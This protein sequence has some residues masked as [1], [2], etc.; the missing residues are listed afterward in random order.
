MQQALHDWGDLIHT[1]VMHPVPITML[2]P[3]CPTTS[4]PVMPP[5]MGWGGLVAQLFDFRQ[6]ANVWWAPY[7]P[8]ITQH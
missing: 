6:P 2:V 7:P 5:S 1:L 4:L 8:T 3:H